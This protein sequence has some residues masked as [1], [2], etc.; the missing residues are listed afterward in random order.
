MWWR[1]KRREFE[2]EQAPDI[3]I[4]TGLFSTFEKAGFVEV[5]RRSA[6][7]PIMRRFITEPATDA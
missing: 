2:K 1:I 6:L 4:Y 3:Y 7:R 5:C